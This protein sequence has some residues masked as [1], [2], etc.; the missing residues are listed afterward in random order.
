MSDHADLLRES[1]DRIFADQLSRDVREA[2]E[3]G[4]WP[5]ALWKTLEENGVTQPLVASWGGGT[6]EEARVVIAAAGRH[7][8]PVPLA[9][10]VLAGWLLDRA[11]LPVPEGPLSLA[12]CGRQ[13]LRL[14]REEGQGGGWCIFGRVERIPW[15]RHVQHLAALG[16]GSEGALVAHI[17]VASAA[18][19]EGLNLAL[20]PRDALHWSTAPAQ[21]A[22]LPGAPP[23]DIHRCYG[24]L[25]RAVQ[26]SGALEHL[27]E[28][29]LRFVS[30]RVQFG[31]PLSRFQVIQHQLA[32][33]AS[34][35]AAAIAAVERACRAVAND[36]APAIEIA[37]AKIRTGEAAGRC[38]RIAHQVHGA[39]GFTYEHALHFATRR[40]WSWR[41]E[42]GSEA[43][44][45][46]Q[47]GRQAAARGPTALWPDLCDRS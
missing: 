39:I 43:E 25:L 17:A 40:L 33:Q 15:G 44:W 12:P 20:E 7:A 22:P 46:E 19:E 8:A 30:E 47:L 26:M 28:E 5:A 38:A 9:E 34:E 10:T 6:W 3:R 27:L 29:S 36:S 24:A 32:I 14:E 4:E 45:A 2:A 13:G 16:E 23:G 11:G 41:A 1:L 37:A 21:V 42:F 18:C 31:R 35:T